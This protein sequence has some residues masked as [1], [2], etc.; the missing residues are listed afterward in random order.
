M[1]ET[2]DQ[3]TDHRMKMFNTL[4]AQ[5]QKLPV[6]ERKPFKMGKNG[7]PVPYSQHEIQTLNPN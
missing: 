3:V 5:Q 4:K 6:F 7:I 1:Q 2:A